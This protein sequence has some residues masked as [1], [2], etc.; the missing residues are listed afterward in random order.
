[1]TATGPP[2]PGELLAAAGTATSVIAGWARHD[3]AR[4]ATPRRRRAFVARE[5]GVLHVRCIVVEHVV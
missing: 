4:T 2:S 5:R 3:P 1:M